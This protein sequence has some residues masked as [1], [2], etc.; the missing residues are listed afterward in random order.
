MK[1]SLLALG[2][3]KTLAM[4]AV[5]FIVTIAIRAVDIGSPYETW[6]EITTYAVGLNQWYNIARLDFSPQSWFTYEQAGS[7]H[8]PM[9]RYVYGIVN[10]IYVFSQTGTKIFSMNQTEAIYTMYTLKS[11]VPGHILSALFAAGTAVLIFFLSRRFFGQRVAIISSL[12][13][14]LLPVVIA[15]TKV[16]ALDAML[17]FM[18]TLSVYLFIRGLKSRKYFC[19]SLLATGLT[20]ATKF[21]AITL[22]VLLPAIYFAFRKPK[23]IGKKHLLLI[24]A[25]SALILYAV[26]PR[27]WLDPIGGML[28]N[29]SWWESLGNVSEYFLGGM[30]HPVYYMATYVIVTA[31]AIVLAMLAIGIA[32]SSKERKFGHLVML[33]WLFIPLFLYSFYHLRQGGARYVFMIYPAFSILAALGVHWVATRVSRFFRGRGRQLIAYSVVPALVLIYLVSIAS[34]V[35]PY[36]LDYYNELA[37]GPKNVYDNKMFALAYMGEGIDA[38]TYWVNEH[39]EFNS[40]VQLFVMPR[41]VIPPLRGDINDLTPFIPNYISGKGN[42]NWYMN[43]TKPEAEY[44]VENLFYRWYEDPAF[45]QKLGTNYKEV[46]SVDVMGAPIAWVYKRV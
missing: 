8:P 17:V 23:A 7:I 31:P 16:A 19:L 45:L 36:Y 9:A 4:V 11:M 1:Y 30:A 28:S 27:L 22:F 14:A 46:Y 34:A 24:P 39:A 33:A 37:G 5:I 10:G 42:I 18:F 21:N 13:F 20:V 15:Q 3:R 40:T 38:A 6:D 12:I 35:D 29:V 43:D 44:L 32:W 25:A 26:W 41:H 2:C